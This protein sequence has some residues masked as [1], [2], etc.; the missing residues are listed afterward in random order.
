ME[1]G[2]DSEVSAKRARRSRRKGKKFQKKVAEVISSWWTGGPKNFRSTPGSGGWD[3]GLAPGDLIPSKGFEEFP[4][5]IECKKRK[6]AKLEVPALLSTDSALR[7]WWAQTTFDAQKS[8]KIPLLIY[9]QDFGDTYLLYCPTQEF[10][11]H[12]FHPAWPTLK[13]QLSEGSIMIYLCKLNDFFEANKPTNSNEGYRTRYLHWR[14]TPE[15]ERE[16]RDA[17]QAGDR[18]PNRG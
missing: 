4:F 1:S 3:K 2:N 13:A 10:I 9:S 14:S 8:D 11:A 7:D 15:G 12:G 16:I 5:S 6:K 17:K 18:F